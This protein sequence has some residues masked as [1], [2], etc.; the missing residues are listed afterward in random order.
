MPLDALCLRGLTAELAAALQ[1]AKIDKIQMP[2]RDMLL[3]SLRT[4]E[5]N[6][7]LLLS[8]GAGSARAN[9]T[10]ASYEQP[11][12]PP[13]FCMLLRKHLVGARIRAVSQPGLERVLLFH[14]D[15]ADEVGE[16]V[17]RRLIL[18]LT[19][20]RTN[21]ILADESRILDCLR[22]VDMEMSPQRQVLPGMVYRLPP[23]QPGRLDPLGTAEADFRA[24]LQA[25]PPELLGEK[26][27]VTA[28]SGISPLLGRELCHL[29]CGDAGARLRDMAPEQLW[30]AL[31][32]LRARVLAGD[33]IPTL[34]S[35]R[36]TGRP[37]D[38]SF[39]PIGQYG[40]SLAQQSYPSF[41][42]LLDAFYTERDRAERIRQ[43]AQ[44]MTRAI[45]RL[46]DRT[47]RKIALQEQEYQKTQDR[48]RLRRFGDIVT[49]NLYRMQKGQR[50]LTAQDFYDEAL[51]EIEIP[52]DPLKTPQQNAARYYKDYNKAKTAEKH[53]TEQ[54][55]KA[56]M[57]LGYLDSVL[58]E[59]Q[60]AGG[61]RDLGEIRQ[62]LQAGGYLPRPG[63]GKKVQKLPPQ[64]PLRFV[65]QSGLEI[66]VGRTG[67]QNDALTK[68]ARPSD[69]WFHSQKIHGSHVILCC[70]GAAPDQA[71]ILDAAAL[72]AYYSQ[73]R[74][75]GR[76][77][78]D[79]CPAKFVK[80]PAGAKPGMVVYTEYKTLLVA[81]KGAL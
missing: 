35:D 38:F 29:A 67:S 60:R 68:A 37:L 50:S 59:I 11:Q 3:F 53:L 36:E 58:D 48:D 74:E 19:G 79:Y 44:T 5:G 62:E 24:A 76:V 54:L 39:L 40:G 64:K 55:G 26:W 75:A 25:A 7:K 10:Q 23:S 21:L 78:V 27:L 43:R 16:P 4:A 69:L 41:S 80:K 12:T 65:S 73:G 17:Q 18:E 20:R 13:M 30:A 52:L 2:E 71:A 61:E 8:A 45:T 14:L 49:A 31:A 63:G 33:L 1:G 57:E 32:A 22:R 42:Q 51:P 46:R 34:L 15:A 6:R 70:Q 28:F 56:R 81:P 9:L 72:A 77:P 66:L 47:A